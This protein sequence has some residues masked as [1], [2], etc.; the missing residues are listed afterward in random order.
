MRSYL[1][2]LAVCFF[3]IACT[4]SIDRNLPEGEENLTIS[5]PHQT[6]KS[7]ALAFL[8]YFN[9]SQ[10]VFTDENGQEVL[11]QAGQEVYVNH[12]SGLQSFPDPNG[13]FHAVDYQY[14]S[15]KYEFT[16]VSTLTGTLLK[17]ELLPRIC[18]DPRLATEDILEDQI[19]ISVLGFWPNLQ[20]PFPNPVIQISAD[21]KVVCIQD[22]FTQSRR[23]AEVTLR[24]KTF[25][26]VFYV[27]RQIGLSQMEAFYNKDWGLLAFRLD[28]IFWVVD[29]FQ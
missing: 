3:L 29:R 13:M 20:Y 14:T 6:I 21:D 23:F 7:E 1:F 10:I 17:I 19:L 11:F 8:P 5:L 9:R 28:D 22:D 25:R 2:S 12:Y 18:E 16:Y 27:T 15:D 4:P 26:E 24:G